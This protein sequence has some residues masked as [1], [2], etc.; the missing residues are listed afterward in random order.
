MLVEVEGGG[1]CPQVNTFEQV[2]SL[3]HQILLAEGGPRPCMGGGGQGPAW[4]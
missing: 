3:G 1:G 2:S 4:E